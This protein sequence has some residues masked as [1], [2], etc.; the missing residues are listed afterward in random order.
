MPKYYVSSGDLNITC[1]NDFPEKAALAAF[2]T[3]KQHPIKE[4]GK[5]TVVS[6]HGFDSNRDDDRYFITADL[7]DETDQLDN[8]KSTEWLE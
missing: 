4:L 6:E 1:D 8:F 3:I 5:L 2:N 7:L